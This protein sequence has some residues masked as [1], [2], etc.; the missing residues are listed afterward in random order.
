MQT[1]TLPQTRFPQLPVVN[2]SR[3]SR[4]FPKEIHAESQGRDGHA[5]FGGLPFSIDGVIQVSR[6]RVRGGE[7]VTLHAH[8]PSNVA[9]IADPHVTF[10]RHAGGTPGPEK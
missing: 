4:H 1:R 5:N 8:L 2:C 9:L 7:E 3:F 10:R 6:E